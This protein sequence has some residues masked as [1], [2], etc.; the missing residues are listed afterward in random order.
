MASSLQDVFD[1]GEELSHTITYTQ[2]IFVSGE[3]KEQLYMTTQAAK[4]TI[5]V[6]SKGILFYSLEVDAHVNISPIF[7]ESTSSNS[8]PDVKRKDYGKMELLQ[9][10]R[11]TQNY[12]SFI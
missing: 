11:K 7:L 12:M 3:H 1:G 8:S 5:T 6:K 2:A 9:K 4:S 10:E